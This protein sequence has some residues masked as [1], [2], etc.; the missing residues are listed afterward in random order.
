[1]P[2]CTLLSRK[3]VAASYFAGTPFLFG[4]D[5][6]SIVPTCFSGTVEGTVTF[7]GR[8][9]P[10]TGSSHSAQYLGPFAAAF[11]N[12]LSSLPLVSVFQDPVG[13]SLRLLADAKTYVELKPA[14]GLGLF[15][16]AL[17]FDDTFLAATPDSSID[18]DREKLVVVGSKGLDAAGVLGIDGPVFSAGASLKGTLCVKR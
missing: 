11:P 3:A 14:A 2:T 6:S 9:I 13:V 7:A 15:T 4:L 17:A 1:M 18:D 16:F 8:T 12:Q 10:V 5:P